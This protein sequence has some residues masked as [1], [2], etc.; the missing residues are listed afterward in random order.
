MA[1][2]AGSSPRMATSD[3]IRIG[4]RQFSGPCDDR[5]VE[6]HASMAAASVIHSHHQ[7][8]VHDRDAEQGG[9]ADAGRD[10]QVHAADVAA[11]WR[12]R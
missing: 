8:A 3:A 12:R 5:L 10:V 11:P 4:R 7:H 1:S 6:R 9:E 2:D